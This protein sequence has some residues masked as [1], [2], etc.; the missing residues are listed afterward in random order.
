VLKTGL[1]YKDQALLL[2]YSEVSEA[3]L[4][5]DLFSW[6]EYS[7]MDLFKQRVLAPLHQARHLEWDRDANT[8][9]L[10]PTGACDVETRILAGEG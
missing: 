9:Q 6:L 7:R 10:S 3:V 5:E 1:S 4:V 2:L 8:V